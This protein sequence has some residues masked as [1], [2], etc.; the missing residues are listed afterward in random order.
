MSSLATAQIGNTVKSFKNSLVYDD[1][2]LKF[3]QVSKLSKGI[4]KF[5]GHYYL[6]QKL[7]QIYLVELVTK[8]GEYKILSQALYFPDDPTKWNFFTVAEFIYEAVGW[9]ISLKKIILIIKPMF[10]ETGDKFM[11][12][13]EYEKQHVSVGTEKIVGNYK[14]TI[15]RIPA[16]DWV[17]TVAD[18][19]TRVG[20]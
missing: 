12:L 17:T 9:S 16:G 13:D 19:S 3:L 15:K 14:F 8:R 20:R 6:S 10:R 11:L 18:R 7:D 2:E 4:F 5:D 1:L